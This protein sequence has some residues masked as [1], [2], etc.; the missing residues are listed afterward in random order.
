MKWDSPSFRRRQW[1]AAKKHSDWI[2]GVNSRA[3]AS[4]PCQDS[5]PWEDEMIEQLEKWHP[6]DDDATR[7]LAMRDGAVV[8]WLQGNNVC[9]EEAHLGQAYTMD[10]L[11]R[12]VQQNTD[13]GDEIHPA[14]RIG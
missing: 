10:R 8:M 12:I 11:R 4:G 2:V 14:L 9:S 3:Y 7:T 5:L 6:D 1:V 13:D